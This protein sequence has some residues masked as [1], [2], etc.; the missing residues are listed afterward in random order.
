[1]KLKYAAIAVVLTFMALNSSAQVYQPAYP[2]YWPPTYS[3]MFALGDT[4]YRTGLHNLIETSTD[5]G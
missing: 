5:E 2:G 1:M 4:W 3:S